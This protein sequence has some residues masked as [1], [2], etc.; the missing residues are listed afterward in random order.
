MRLIN[1]K[2]FKLE[3]FLDYKTPPYA[4]LSHTWGDDC[5]EL[6]FRDVE[7]GK[8]DKPGVGRVK[9][10]GSCRQAEKDGLGYVWIDTCCID[11]ANL[12]ELS[13]AINS[14]FRWYRRASLCYAYLSDV[15]GDDNPRKHGSK[16]RT[17]R[18]FGR[19]WTL[20]ELLAPKDLRFYNSAW[21]YLG[22]KGTM[23]AVIGKITG[24][25]RQFLLGITELHSASVAQRMSWA[26]G[27]DTKRK[28]DLAYCLLGIFGVTMPMIY[29]E[30]GDQAFFRLQEQ[31]MK[32]TRDDSI[33]AW[34]LSVKESPT[35][36][37]GQVS[38][39]RILAATPSDFANSGQI[40]SREIS[41]MPLHSL[42][43]S[44]GS[45]RMYLSL[46]TT[47]AGKTI[48]LLNC[49]PGRDIQQVVGIPLAKVASGSDQYF[50]PKG[51]HAVL[52]PITAP[53]A[54]PT[55]IHIRN[56]GL[57]KK[58][59]DAN[60]QYW[61]YDDDE[62][63]E[64]NLELVD[65]VPRSC[66]DQER[67]VIISTIASSNG[68]SHQTLARFRHNEG[69]SRDF[70]IVLEF[71]QQGTCIEAQCC[72]MICCR[73][74]SLQELTEKL[75]YVTQKAS[76]KRSASNG[77]LHLGVTLEPDA[78]QPM[79]AIKPEALPYPPDVTVDATIELQ[80]SDLMLELVETLEEIGRSDAEE[81]ELNQRAKCKSNRLEW[82][83]R[84]REMVEDELKNLEERRRMLVEEESN[85]AQEIRHL[86]E[87]QAEI[88][89]NQ[90]RA[91]KRWSHAR[92]RWEE[93]W[94]IDGDEDG[95]ELERIDGWT[96]LRWAAEKGYVEMVELLRWTAE[97][98]YAEMVELL[99]KKGADVAVANKDGW[100]PL[101]AAS[102]KG[103][104]DVARLLLAAGGANADCKDTKY[105]Q[106]PLICA[107]ANGHEAVA[108]LLLDTGKVDANSKDNNGRTPLSW[109][110]ERGHETVV[111][112]LLQKGADVNVKDKDA[113]TALSYA[114]GAE[115]KVII[116]LLLR[117]R[118]TTAWLRQTLEGHSHYVS[119]VA[120]SPDSRVLASA[121]WDNTVRLWDTAT[122]R[123]RQTLEGHSHYV[124]SVAFS[125]DSKMLASASWD[126]T[127]RLWDTATGRLQQTLKGHRHHA[128]SV[129]FSPDS[130]VLA[131]ASYDNSVRLWDTAMGRLRRTLEG[132][133]DIVSSVAF[134]PDSKLLASASTDKTVRLWDTAPGRLRQTFEDH[135]NNVLSVAFSPDSKVLA[136]ASYDKTVRLWDMATGRL[137]QTLEGHN[138][139]VSSVA[140]SPDSKMLAS[141][142]C[143][144]TVRLWDTAAG[145]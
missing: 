117:S 76:G 89:E 82:V 38:A 19:G 28:E 15:P 87:R 68:A 125:P 72:V 64:V 13:E 92:T 70:V 43:L 110:A 12:V 16:F 104:V 94:H 123:L 52:R 54:S 86:S 20:Q 31:I 10:R 78:Q 48:G 132:H 137:R 84:E 33:L 23:R 129:A 22:N 11:K 93:L 80:K 6:T 39:G 49:G 101:I 45:L 35:S 81:E 57:S 32:T 37:P 21:G 100:T 114:A 106:T 108:Q 75:Q 143:D 144:K 66:W 25:P 44:G 42:D 14:M 128:L 126:N 109:A 53:S 134:S 112:L 77:L 127:V 41:T 96:L 105:G 5:E 24:V 3:E 121:S 69:G 102:S 142:S 136:S 115:H 91:F 133:N 90:E 2:S 116:Q 40:V 139:P 55:L 26:A 59:A 29:G 34:G 140:F 124:S 107:A 138:D 111:Q 135:S 63:A 1:V 97:K 62:F 51:C 141:A 9:F 30:G 88:K 122:G 8:F 27:R 71:K 130:K 131:S 47:S 99:L 74:T 4:I 17:S 73:N 120:F 56:D 83:K 58:S 61:L 79:F 46:L 65:V 98:G 36:D 118:A 103:H 145:A 95:Y 113:R 67:A 50:R 119:S 85:R 60:Q 7:E 18:W